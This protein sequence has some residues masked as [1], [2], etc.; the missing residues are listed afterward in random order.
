MIITWL[1]CK[2][3]L[4]AE[5]LMATK[6]SRWI[7]ISHFYLT[8]QIDLDGILFKIFST[9]NIVGFSMTV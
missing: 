8:L 9:V 5:I 4:F 7:I 3:W 2:S 1:N 6:R